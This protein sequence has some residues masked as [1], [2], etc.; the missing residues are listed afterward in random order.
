MSDSPLKLA[1]ITGSVRDGRFGPTVARWFTG[2]AAKHDGVK[3]T[4]IDLLDHPLPLVMPDVSAG[5]QAQGATRVVAERLGQLLGE[6]DAFVVVTPEYNHSVPASLKNVLDW[7]ID[8]WKAK[9]VGLVS[10]G[11]LAGGL[12]AVEHLRQIFAELNSVT[13][14]DTV[15]FHHAWTDFGADGEEVCP[16]GSDTAA[17][18]MLDQLVWWGHALRDA[19]EKRPF[20]G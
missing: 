12:R 9:P 15:S 10:Y 17:K 16:A 14:R 19:R 6:A 18:A 20:A 13:L 4:P 7:Y 8:E 1:I 3:V 5:A 11:G 2:Q